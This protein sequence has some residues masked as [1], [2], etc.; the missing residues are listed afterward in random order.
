MI[1]TI[2]LKI[3]LD[4]INLQASGRREKYGEDTLETVNTIEF[5]EGVRAV[6]KNQKR[7]PREK[8]KVKTRN[9]SKLKVKIKS[10][11]NSFSVSDFK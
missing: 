9:L 7:E 10:L 6:E 4:K 3:E 2:K 8:S 11:K 1:R 5:L